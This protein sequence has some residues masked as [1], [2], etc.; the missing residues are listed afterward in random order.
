MSNVLNPGE[1][2]II[3]IHIILNINSVVVILIQNI[4]WVSELAII[5][6]IVKILNYENHMY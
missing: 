6:K 5:K 2:S 3:L 1:K 4:E